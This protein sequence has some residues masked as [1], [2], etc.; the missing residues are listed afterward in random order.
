MG[1]DPTT[2]PDDEW[3]GEEEDEEAEAAE[4][5]IMVAFKARQLSILEAIEQMVGLGYD[6]PEAERLVFQWA[7]E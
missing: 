4:V 5:E 2:N 3:L 7:R 6:E 1:Y